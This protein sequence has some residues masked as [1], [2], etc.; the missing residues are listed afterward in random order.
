MSERFDTAVRRLDAL[1]AEDPVKELVNGVETPRL[2][3]EADR[4]TAWILHLSPKASESLRLAARAQH[5]MR[6]KVKRSDYPEGRIGYRTWR[7]AAMD[8]H[9]A[10]ARRV[11]ADVGYDERTI[12]EVAEIVQKHGLRKNADVQTMED[13]LCLAFLERDLVAFA[14]KHDDDKLVHILKETWQKMSD[15]GH[16]A[17]LSVVPQLPERLQ[18]LVVKASA[19]GD[20]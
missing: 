3:A 15:A 11:L 20:T 10:E 18:R 1:N 7:R 2:I 17:A 13:A 16:R 6:W 14:Q 19:W 5:L 8:F 12:A 9:A 4:V